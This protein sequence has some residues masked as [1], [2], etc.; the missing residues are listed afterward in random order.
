MKATDLKTKSYNQTIVNFKGSESQL[1]EAVKLAKREARKQ[2]EGTNILP[3]LPVVELTGRRFVNVSNKHVTTE[4]IDFSKVPDPNVFEGTI[5]YGVDSSWK[6]IKDLTR[7]KN[8]CKN[9]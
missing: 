5:T 2:V 3:S 8:A 1:I 6:A 4:I 7:L 9:G